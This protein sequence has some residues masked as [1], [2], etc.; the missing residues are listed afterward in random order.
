MI[1]N[2]ELDHQLYNGGMYIY[3]C[4]TPKGFYVSEPVPIL[5]FD[6][7]YFTEPGHLFTLEDFLYL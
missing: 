6:D 1:F 4:Q 2:I 5:T 3:G 7:L